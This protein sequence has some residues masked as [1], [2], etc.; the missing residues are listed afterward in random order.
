MLTDTLA[1]TSGPGE[2]A[3]Q[4]R[5]AIPAGQEPK[6]FDAIALSPHP[7]AADVLCLIGKH[8]PDKQI[9]KAARVLLYGAL[10]S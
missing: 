5:D 4:V 7:D 8:H 6:A 3:Q 1:A 10:R 2:L 9:A